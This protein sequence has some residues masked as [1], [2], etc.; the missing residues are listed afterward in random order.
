MSINR[1]TF[2]PVGNGDTTL[3]E[4]NDK[5][6]LT[7]INYRCE[8]YTDRFRSSIDAN[9]SIGNAATLGYEEA[10]KPFEWVYYDFAL[11]LQYA[12]YHSSYRSNREY[13]LSLFVLTHPDRNNLTGFD[14]LFYQGDPAE[15]EDRPREDD[16]LILIEEMWIN[17]CFADSKF[18]TDESK[19]L[20]QEIKRRLNLQGSKE[21]ELNGNRICILEATSSAGLVKTFSRNI[22]AHVFSPVQKE[23]EISK[24]VSGEDQ[25]DV[26]DSSLVIRWTVKVFGGVNRILLGGDATVEVWD[27]IWQNYKNDVDKLS[28]HILL[29]PHHCSI[30]AIARKNKEGKYEYSENA[31]NAL[32]QVEGAGF[33][34]SSSEE[35]KHNDSVLPSWEAKQKYLEILKDADESRFFNPDTRANA[36]LLYSQRQDYKP[37]SIEFNLTKEGPT[38]D[39]PAPAS[40][41]TPKKITPVETGNNEFGHKWNM[42]V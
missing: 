9:C 23:G 40:P 4:A 22:E 31:L 17:A 1:V 30:D 28:W 20:F 24:A 8:R 11:D 38:I 34:V 35:I 29:A 32:S 2:F 33:V 14:K 18:E 26:N 37:E 5:T 39:A 21:S 7:D 13:R 16:K 15:F 36:P 42:K 25:T 3:I 6:I 19:P 10:S 12:C 27:R 41:H